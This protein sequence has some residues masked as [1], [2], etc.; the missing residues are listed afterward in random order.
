[1]KITQIL[2]VAMILAIYVTPFCMA[3]RNHHQPTTFQQL[4]NEIRENILKDEQLTQKL[5][6]FSVKQTGAKVTLP[7]AG[8]SL[9]PMCIQLLDQTINQLLNVILNSGVIGKFFHTR[10]VY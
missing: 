5:L 7:K 4:K 8:F 6:N 1:M 10:T 9:C 3:I 2:L